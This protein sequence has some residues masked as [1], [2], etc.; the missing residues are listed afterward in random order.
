MQ[1]WSIDIDQNGSDPEAILFLNGKAAEILIW[2]NKKNVVKILEK[3][4][5]NEK[6]IKIGFCGNEPVFIMKEKKGA[7]IIIGD[8]ESWV[9]ALT[10]SEKERDSLRKAI[11]NI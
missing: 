2:I 5:Q 7:T 10:L 11:E 8:R 4:E 3:F 1:N 6:E 9:S